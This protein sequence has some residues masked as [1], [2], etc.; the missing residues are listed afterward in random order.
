MTRPERPRGSW[1]ECRGG[2]VGLAPRLLGRV[3]LPH[4]PDES[5]GRRVRLATA[6]VTTTILLY[7]IGHQVA[8]G[9][10]PGGG[11]LASL[12]LLSG[13]TGLLHLWT[14]RV[15]VRRVVD[16][17]LVYQVVTALLL[18]LAVNR[19]PWPD[20]PMPPS[21]SPI[22]GLI[23][24][25][26]LLVPATPAQTLAAGLSAAAM[27][28]LSMLFTWPA[29]TPTSWPVIL[30]RS[31]PNVLAALVA[32]AGVRVVHQLKVSVE[33][34]RRLGSYE[35]IQR[36]GRGGMGEVWSARHRMLARPAAI[37][38]I[39]P[40]VC[41]DEEARA[42]LVTRF[43]REARATASLRSPHTIVTYD[44]GTTAD[45]TFFYAMELLDGVDL[46]VLVERFGPLPP[47]RVVRFLVQITRSLREAHEKGL[48]HRD[49]KPANVMVC[50]YGSEVDFVKVLDFGLVK[51]LAPGS[52]APAEPTEPGVLAGTPAFLAPELA[53][54][55]ADVDGRADLY[56]LGALAYWL[57]TGRLV[58]EEAS[59]V[60]TV[61]A[62]LQDPPV[63]P[64]RYAEEPVPPALNDLV[65][66]LLEKDPARRPQSAAAVEAIL[67]GIVCDPPWDEE[68]A[69]RWWRGH[70]P[71]AAA[72]TAGRSSPDPGGAS[73]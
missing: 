71:A 37:K 7:L 66:R 44:F 10:A 40:L 19:F 64:S 22:A 20:S 46:K 31:V 59:A 72:K 6:L 23:L 60:R 1:G 32:Y 28:P 70:L 57:L 21:L 63:E 41:P 24:V 68:R 16:L 5:G 55:H 14:S 33:A 12:A 8:L 36:L 65:M 56:S 47:A 73:S 48:V 54:G 18:G 26:P 51:P 49:I 69:K 27:D 2:S 4:A 53:L 67:E 58:F 17:A 3:E 30:L 13:V 42:T 61:L 34:A 35:L 25:F 29:G 62:H 39:G 52:S 15:T 43:E 9:S 50:R 38:V 11:D 45:G